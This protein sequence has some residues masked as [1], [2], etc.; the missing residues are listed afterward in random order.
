LIPPIQPTADELLH[1]VALLI[2][3]NDSLRIMAGRHV[4]GEGRRTYTR[5]R[6]EEAR[7]LKPTATISPTSLLVVSING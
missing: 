2:V 6:L 4:L 3:E 7:Q 5:D 1:V